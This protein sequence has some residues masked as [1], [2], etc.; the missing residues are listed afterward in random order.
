MFSQIV[1]GLMSTTHYNVDGTAMPDRSY[2]YVTAGLFP[3][4][5]PDTTS[6][7]VETS[8]Y[9]LIASTTNTNPAVSNSLSK[10]SASRHPTISTS[11]TYLTTADSL[12]KNDGTYTIEIEG[13]SCEATILSYTDSSATLSWKIVTVTPAI[14][15][16]NYISPIN[17]QAVAVKDYLLIL[18]TYALTISSHNAELHN[19]DSYAP[20]PS[21][22]GFKDPPST[23]IAQQGQWILD[24]AFGL[25]FPGFLVWD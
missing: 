24:R 20:L 25:S 8:T 17:R 11:A 7:L 1:A 6:Y 18:I 2:D 13:V 9:Y 15:I 21:P 10:A 14:G 22:L 3:Y 5:E 23:G 19:A 16:V 4:T 12:W